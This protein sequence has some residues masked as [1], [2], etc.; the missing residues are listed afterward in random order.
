MDMVE[1]YGH[2]ELFDSYT[3]FLLARLTGSM[4]ADEF[5]HIAG[6]KKILIRNC[7]NFDGLSHNYIRFSLKTR[8]ENARLAALTGAVMETRAIA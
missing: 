6:Q 2:I 7:T 3:Y 4:T 5:C 8:Q 1:E